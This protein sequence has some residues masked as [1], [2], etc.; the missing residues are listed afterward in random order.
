MGLAK[1]IAIDQY[2]P[3]ATKEELDNLLRKMEGVLDWAINPNGEV[4]VEYDHDLINDEM[5]EAALSGVGLKL[6]H[7]SDDLDLPDEIAQE[8]LDQEE[9][10]L[11]T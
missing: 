7:I 5:I 3:S 9:Y 10:G 8:E 11:R 6:K 1:F 4:A 2:A